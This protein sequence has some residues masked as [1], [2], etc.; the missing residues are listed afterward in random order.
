MDN[1]GDLMQAVVAKLYAIVTGDDESIKIPRNKFVSWFLP[2]VPFA[3]EDF[4]FCVRGFVGD[5]AEDVHEAYHQAFVLST[6]F[7]YV[8]DVTAG[9]V[10]DQ[11]QQTI[12]AGS[13]D[14]I[15]S[16]YNDVLKY[17]RVVHR[18]LSE[19]EQAKL[20]K[21]RDLLSVEVEEKDILTDEVR[22]VSKP[23]KLAIAY[24]ERMNEYLDVA[25]ELMNMKIDAMAATGEDPEAKRR[26]FNWNEKSKFL[27][28]RLDAAEMAWTAQGYKNEYETISAYIAQVA[29]KNLVLYK[30]DLKR[31]FARAQLTSAAD[32]DSDF[33]YTTLLPGN[34]AT[35]AGWTGFTFTSADFETHSGKNTNEWGAG[36][37]GLLGIFAIG[38]KASGSKIETRDDQKATNFSASF[39]F[40]QIPIARPWFEPGFF[41]MRS[42]TLDENWK[43]SYADS[44]VSDGGSPP[45]GRLVAYPVSALFVRNVRLTSS[46]WSNHTEFLKKATSASGGVGIGPFRV[47]GKYASGSEERSSTYHFEGD[48]LVIDGM[49]LA[50]TINSVVPACPNPHPDLK[51]EDFVGGE[52]VAVEPVP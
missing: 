5:T 11:M 39:E 52:Q 34:F 35:S 16:V 36:G 47:G 23:G 9:F 25:D 49:Q 29:E 10:T 21:F 31:K 51:P 48:T 50:G 6:L 33:Y 17:S 2:G 12:F 27:R 41:S 44:P 4:K 42:W 3:P 45:A 32:G 38:G 24:T 18:E 7:D 8:P 28:K 26:V 13:Q 20:K 14:R 22:T 37:A 40:T 43:L 46:S 1:S 19:A 30:E 15:S